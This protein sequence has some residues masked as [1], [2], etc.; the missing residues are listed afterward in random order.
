M[1]FQQLS[2]NF[3]VAVQISVEDLTPIAQAGFKSI[4]C[5]RPD[6][7]GPDQ[8]NFSII[9]NAAKAL[10]LQTRYLPAI[11]GQVSSDHGHAMALLLKELPG[12]VLAYCRSGARST[13]IWQLAQ[14]SDSL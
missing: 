12:P 7:E 13:N 3:A 4:I 14:Q 8:T 11:S 6:N 1:S 9:E 2:S 10:G 5:N